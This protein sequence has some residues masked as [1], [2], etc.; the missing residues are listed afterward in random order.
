MS[1]QPCQIPHAA[2]QVAIAL[3]V[4]VAAI[5]LSC[6]H[7]VSEPDSSTPF[8]I[9]PGTQVS[10]GT[11]AYNIVWCD[12]GAEIAFTSLDPGGQI[13]HGTVMTVNVLSGATRTLDG[14][15]RIFNAFLA[16]G[17][18]VFYASLDPDNGQRVY[19]VPDN[20][21]NVPARQVGGGMIIAVSP[22]R[23]LLASE[24]L[25]DTLDVVHLADDVSHRYPIQEGEHVE[26]FSPDSRQIL[27][28]SGRLLNL[29]DGSF[30]SIPFPLPPAP[31]S[32]DWTLNG[33]Y[34]VTTGGSSQD[35]YRLDN[36]LTGSVTDL[37]RATTVDM[38]GSGWVWSSDGR[39]FAFIRTSRMDVSPTVHYLY[40]CDLQSGTSTL[41]LEVK[42]RFGRGTFAGLTSFAFSP[43]GRRIAYAV[44]GNI[45]YSNI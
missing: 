24:S 8:L 30:T 41:V 14:T 2:R 5:G 29:T 42:V 9:G 11:N 13:L 34:A 22:D 35:V 12:G 6:K 16:A 10:Q 1:F 38:F 15:T 44:E 23:T 26:T 37:W 39:K 25:F 43:D 17:D 32:V 40:V 45:Y 36:L 4:V 18:S 31:Y 27:L 28:T 33:L 3:L 21:V 19:V 7:A 20:G